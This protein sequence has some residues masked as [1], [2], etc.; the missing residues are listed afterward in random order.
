MRGKARRAPHFI[1]HNFIYFSGALYWK[2]IEYKLSLIAHPEES[3][4]QKG[5]QK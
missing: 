5:S 2:K 3:I 4:I 1:F